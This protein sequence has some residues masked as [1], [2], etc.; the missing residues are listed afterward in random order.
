MQINEFLTYNDSETLNIYNSAKEEVDFFSKGKNNFKL[1]EKF[2]EYLSKEISDGKSDLVQ[3][4]YDDIK[5]SCESLS[6][7]FV[8]KGF[9][10]WFCSLFNKKSYL[11][12][13]ID[14]MIDTFLKK[15]SIFKILDHYTIIYLN[16]LLRS[17]KYTINSVTLKFNEE[18]IKKWKEACISYEKTRE[19]IMKIRNINK[20]IKQ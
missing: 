15:I 20:E 13:I 5:Y 8:K 1:K 14:I 7:I 19:I 18:Q 12:N 17:I 4:I 2:M 6:N 3:E 16:D 11:E 10:Q 9:K